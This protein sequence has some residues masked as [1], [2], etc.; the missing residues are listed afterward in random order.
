MISQL[1]YRS[2]TVD[3]AYHMGLVV[4]F[5]QFASTCDRCVCDGDALLALALRWWLRLFLHSDSRISIS[6]VDIA[7]AR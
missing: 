6:G 4:L 2:R 7:I 5:C 3:V 1:E